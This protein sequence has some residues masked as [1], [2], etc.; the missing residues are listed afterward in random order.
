MTTFAKSVRGFLEQNDT[1]LMK[2]VHRWRPPRWLRFWTILITRL[3]DGWLWYALALIVLFFGGEKRYVAFGAGL[4][5][6]LAGILIFRQLKLV[7]KRPRPYQVEPH[8]WSMITTR[9]RFSFP[10]GHSMTAFSIFVSVGHFYPELQLLLLLLAISIAASR[11][12]LG[13][14]YLTDVVAGAAIGLGLGL[15]SLGLV[16]LIA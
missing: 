4:T 3:G 11:I 15:A 14:H 12:I 5:A 8:C 2:R 6:S 9:D 10:S 7:S 16:S 13:M 1:R